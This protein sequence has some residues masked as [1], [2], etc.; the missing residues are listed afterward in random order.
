AVSMVKTHPN[1]L[2]KWRL[3]VMPIARRN[4]LQVLIL[5]LMVVGGGCSSPTQNP[6]PLPEQISQPQN[7]PP[8]S[9]RRTPQNTVK[10]FNLPEVEGLVRENDPVAITGL[11][12][13]AEKNGQRSLQIEFENVSDKPVKLVAFLFAH[14]PACPEFI[15]KL[16]PQLYYGDSSLLEVKHKEKDPILYPGQKSLKR[17]K[18]KEY[19]K[20]LSPGT[21]K[22]CPFEPKKPH[23]IL[24]KVWFEDGT[25]WDPSAEYYRRIHSEDPPKS[26]R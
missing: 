2:T 13:I 7:Q 19:S 15:Y 24:R 8:E 26:S 1:H 18:G 12:V 11:N 17:F 16:S 3:V 9:K 21:Y 5:T 4:L 22:D 20:M 25:V 10:E 14:P 23:L 6:Q